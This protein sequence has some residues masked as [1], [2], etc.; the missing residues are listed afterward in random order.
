MHTTTA[1]VISYVYGQTHMNTDTEYQK[2]K[3]KRWLRY[4]HML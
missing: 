4:L 1:A 3:I 2:N